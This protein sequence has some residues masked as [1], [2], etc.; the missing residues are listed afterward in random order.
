MPLYPS[1]WGNAEYREYSV[2]VCRMNTCWQHPWNLT[3]AAAFVDVPT[4]LCL[5]TDKD[6]DTPAFL[7]S[8]YGWILLVLV[9][10]DILFRKCHCLSCPC[11]CAPGMQ[12]WWWMPRRSGNTHSLSQSIASPPPHPPGSRGSS[13]HKR[14]AEYI[15]HDWLT[16]CPQILV[17]KS[18][19]GPQGQADHL[20]WELECFFSVTIWG[21]SG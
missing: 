5:C 7:N 1:I 3:V 14:C 13:M 21:C 19:A 12:T 10:I 2:G 9:S 15:C 20:G 8:A 18:W 6:L 11:W 4:D 17:W 16:V